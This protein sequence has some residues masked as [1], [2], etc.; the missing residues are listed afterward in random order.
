MRKK[1]FLVLPV[2]LLVVFLI[3][4]MPT[5]AAPKHDGCSVIYVVQPGDTMYS[6][7][8]RYGV[9]MWAI[10]EANGIVNPN[11]IY[12]GQRLIIPVC[13]PAPGGTVHVVQPGET[14]TQIS[15]R[16][17]VSV[18]A[19][20]E[21]NGLTNINYIYVGQRLVIPG[22]APAPGPAPTAAPSGPTTF[23]GPWQG[24]YFDNVG[25]TGSAFTT[26]EDAAVS[27]NWG[28]GPPAG[29][30][31]VNYF[32]V[33]WTG[34]FNFS[35]GTYRFYAKVD[36][37]VRV[38]VDGTEVINGWR[39]GGLRTY[40]ADRAMS[41]GDHE[42]KVEYYDTIQVAAIYVWW[43]KVSG[44]TVTPGPSPTPTSGAAA[45]T[46]GWQAEF[47][48]NENL[49]GDPVVTRVDP[50]IG[51]EWEG[52]GPAPGVW[53]DGFSARWTT[54]MH[55]DADHYRFCTMSDDGSRIW[56]NGELVLDEWHANN[57]IAYCGTYYATTG[58]YEVVVEYYEHGG[59]ALIYMWWEPH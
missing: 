10:A 31:P 34:T 42:V 6:I 40:K 1:W 29:A 56:V 13:P 7:A 43:E 9:S 17:G 45:P 22:T 8:R 32:S 3:A 12:V 24:E 57:G 37:G 11:F 59:K 41:A 36:D 48:N 30:M 47:F 46:T 33:R 26:R 35:E 50:W 14:L 38:Y 55:L 39:E 27:F 44:P 20:A 51:F 15:A 53:A 52:D 23:P 28:W 18:W 21:A 49:E 4:A 58:D 19:I 54:T 25:L 5:A 2:V 16:Y